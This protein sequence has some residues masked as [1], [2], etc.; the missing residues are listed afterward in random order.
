MIKGELCF[1]CVPFFTNERGALC[2][3]PNSG[4]D[5]SVFHKMACDG[6]ER[7]GFVPVSPMPLW[8]Y[9]HLEDIYGRYNKKRI[10]QHG[11]WLIELCKYFYFCDCT[12]DKKVHKEMEVWRLRAK[13]LNKKFISIDIDRTFLE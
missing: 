2:K 1:V 11:D 4:V 13:T 5:Y 3:D 6:V 10:I 12:Y 8:E 9:Y 7:A